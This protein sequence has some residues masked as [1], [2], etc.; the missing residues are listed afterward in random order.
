[1]S[2]YTE[3]PLEAL[4]VLRVMRMGPARAP[5]LG[6]SSATGIRHLMCC[7]PSLDGLPVLKTEHFYVAVNRKVMSHCPARKL[8][9]YVLFDA[10]VVGAAVA[11]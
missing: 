1:M 4:G 8:V 9:S 3:A 11:T 10:F 6:A 5:S 7:Q 2:R